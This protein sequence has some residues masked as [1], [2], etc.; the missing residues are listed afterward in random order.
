M[1]PAHHRLT[2]LTIARS[3]STRRG[4]ARS[5]GA[6]A[7]TDRGPSD[8]GGDSGCGRRWIGTAE[9]RC[10]LSGRDLLFVGNSV[11]RRQMC[12]R[13]GGQ[14]GCLCTFHPPLLVLRA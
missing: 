12:A 13:G 10:L 3:S 7:W 1:T 8:F 5:A 2:R 4:C 9:A 6:A 11:T 14:G